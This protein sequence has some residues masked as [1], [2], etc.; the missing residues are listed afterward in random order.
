LWFDLLW[1]DRKGLSEIATETNGNSAEWAVILPD[2]LKH[3]VYN[4]EGM[5]AL[6]GS[7]VPEDKVSVWNQIAG[8]TIC[9]DI[10]G[11]VSIDRQKEP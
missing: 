6:Q 2:I 7:L 3:T 4:F 11:G 1:N 8:S 9:S 10:A 5:A